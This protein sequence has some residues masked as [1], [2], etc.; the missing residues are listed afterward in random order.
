ME[1]ERIDWSQQVEN[2]HYDFLVECVI[3]SPRGKVVHLGL[4]H[5][6]LKER[7]NKGAELKHVYLVTKFEMEPWIRSIAA[8]AG[9]LEWFYSENDR[10]AAL[11][12]AFPF[13]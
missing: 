13:A 8:R 11:D 10:H 1:A 3:A 2:Q 4:N 9:G 7:L 6:W 12:D 5:L